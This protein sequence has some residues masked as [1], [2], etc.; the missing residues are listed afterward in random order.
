MTSSQKFLSQRRKIPAHAPGLASKTWIFSYCYL[1][2]LLYH[3]RD[4]Q[5][6]I[7][8]LNMSYNR[9]VNA[10]GFAYH[11]FTIR[12]GLFEARVFVSVKI[13]SNLFYFSLAFSKLSG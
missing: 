13:R 4:I 9:A 3:F 10:N 1:P 5:P 7:S 12:P 8:S 11:Y 2:L 6:F